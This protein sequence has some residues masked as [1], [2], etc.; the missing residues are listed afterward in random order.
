[1]FRRLIRAVNPIAYTIY[2]FLVKLQQFLIVRSELRPKFL[3]DEIVQPASGQTYAIVVKYSKFMGD[4]GVPELAAVLRER[5]INVVVI[6]NGVPPDE[7][8]QVLRKSAHRILV[9]RN[10]GRDF[11]AYRAG[12][13]LLEREGVTPSRLLYFNDSV[14]YLD[15]PELRQVV[16]TLATSTMDLQG[17]FEN[18]ENHHH[19]GSFAFS[20]S[21]TVLSAPPVMKFWRRYRPYDLRPHAINNGE[22]LLSRT[23]K[24]AGFSVDTLYSVQGLAS[25]LDG[26][27]AAELI[28]LLRYLPSRSHRP[29]PVGLLGV[30]GQVATALT[31]TR[32]ADVPASPSATPRIGD[33]R[34]TQSTRRSGINEQIRDSRLVKDS[35][36]DELLSS[37]MFNSQ[38]HYGFGLFYWVMKAP[39]V[40]KDLILR[41]VYL[42]HESLR[43]LEDL[44][45][46]KAQA[47]V[48]ILLNRGR[49][50]RP[51]IVE[52][53]KYYNGLI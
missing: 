9:R 50:L 18:H 23:I 14:V 1:M 51:S 32:W 4:D 45:A 31:R 36:I 30:P 33:F 41:G 3:S 37:F 28:G 2:V 10:V 34:L 43:V 48:R 29:H 5:N 22:V 6:C 47:I 11:G 21:G 26:M 49:P 25:R 24:A 17:V 20:V 15:G 13:L 19:I 27:P 38:V 40:K 35:L 44:P 53:F 12:T 52:K 42:E 46:E 16:E 7:T 8:L 39:L